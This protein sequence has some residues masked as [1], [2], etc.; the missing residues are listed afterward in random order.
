MPPVA[1]PSLP[2]PAAP[3]FPNLMLANPA[4][5]FD[6]LLGCQQAAE[7]DY[8][9]NRAAE[10][11]YG[12]LLELQKQLK[13]AE[14]LL[15]Q[16]EQVGTAQFIVEGA[17][18]GASVGDNE[19]CRGDAGAGGAGGALFRHGVCFVR[20]CWAMSRHGR[21]LGWDA[22]SQG[23]AVKQPRPGA[24]SAP[25]PAHCPALPLLPRPPPQTNRMLH[26]EVTEEDIA[27]I[28]S[29]WT[30]IPVSSLK[31]R[32]G[33]GLARAYECGAQMYMGSQ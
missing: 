9:L 28:V 19:G 17:C 10:L 25:P 18:C 27:E 31:A 8:D 15:E 2:H 21:R 30:G 32:C 14:A 29:K 12:T 22:S 33:R 23:A 24:H 6:F 26:S 5:L 1:V 3:S 16:A 20:C 11:K 7:R 4:H 13:D